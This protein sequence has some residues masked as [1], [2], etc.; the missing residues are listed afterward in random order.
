MSDA[1]R[2]FQTIPFRNSQKFAGGEIYRHDLDLKVS[3]SS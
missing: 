2:P 3:S 1:A